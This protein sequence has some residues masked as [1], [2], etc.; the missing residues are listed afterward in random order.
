MAGGLEGFLADVDIR[1]RADLG[2]FK[3][4]L[5]LT[6]GISQ[7]RVNGMFEVISRPSDVY[8]VLRVGEVA[9]LPLDRVIAEYKLHHRQ[10][11]GVMA[12]NLGIKPGSAA[13]HSLKAGRL[14]RHGGDAF[15]KGKHKRGK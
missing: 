12:K 7:G 4:D 11:W 14:P 9:N 2:S 3:A 6:F 5:G 15:L 10:G 1:A 13:F 8:M